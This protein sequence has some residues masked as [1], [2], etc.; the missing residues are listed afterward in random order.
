[1]ALSEQEQ[2]LLDQLEASLAADDPS[3]ARTLRGEA[4]GP[5]IMP[6]RR[7]GVLV[8]GFFVGLGGLVGG[9]Q[10]HPVVSV[11]GFVIMLISAVLLA[12]QARADGASQPRSD[13]DPRLP[14]FPSHTDG[15]DRTHERRSQD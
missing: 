1:M 9:M 7:T 12:E 6:P 10:V 15:P 4:P 11:L 3:L 13:L 5:R 14:G 8:A 2:R